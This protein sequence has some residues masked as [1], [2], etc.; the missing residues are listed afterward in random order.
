MVVFAGHAGLQHA[1]RAAR[2]LWRRDPGPVGL[3]DD[4]ADRGVGARARWADFALPRAGWRRGDDP[5]RIAAKGMLAGLAAFSAVIFAAPL[6]NA[7]RCSSSAPSADRLWRR[8]VRGGDADSRDDDAL[9]AAIR[10]PR[11]C[12]GRLGRRAGHRGRDRDL[13]RRHHP[14][15]GRRHQPARDTL[16]RPPDTAIG[17]S[18]GDRDCSSPLS[19]SSGLS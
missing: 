6:E 16:G 1:G 10:R 18:R 13:R 4:A 19:P 15:R 14:R 2:A 17:L 9:P 11:P 3:G 8:P 7:H 5:Y 12:A